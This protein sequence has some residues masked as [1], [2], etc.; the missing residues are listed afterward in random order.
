MEVAMTMVVNNMNNH[1]QTGK[2]FVVISADFI[3]TIG[4]VY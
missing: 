3:E 1:W 2:L 4:Q